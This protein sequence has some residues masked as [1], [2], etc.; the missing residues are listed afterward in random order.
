MN[1]DLFSCSLIVSAQ[2][3]PEAAVDHPETIWQLAK[4]S[5]DQGV[6]VLRLQGISNIRYIK[7]RWNGPVI[8]LIKRDFA[9]SEIY[10]TPTKQEVSELIEAGVEVIALDATPRK[11]PGDESLQELVQLIHSKG[12]RAMGD[13]DSPESIDYAI[14][15]GCDFIGT[16]LAGYTPARKMTPGPDF[17]LLRYAVSKGFPVIA[18][19]RYSERWEVE[20]ALRIGASAVV[21][22]GAINDPVKQTNRFLIPNRSQEKIGAVDIGGTWIRFAVFQNDSI[23]EIRKEPLPQDREIRMQWIRDQ[24]AHSGVKRLGVGTG[25][26]VDPRTGEVW[27]AKPIIPGHQGSFFNQQMLGIPT[28]ALNDGLATAFGHACHPKFAGKNVATLALGTGVGA[29]FIRRGEILHG[30]RGEYPRLNDV[31]VGGGE[32]VEQHLGGAALSPNPTQEQK[33]KA[34]EAVQVVVRLVQEMMYPDEIVIAGSVGLS[35]WLLPI[36]QELNCT[37]SP[38]GSDAGLYGSYW[39][40]RSSF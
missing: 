5:L 29:G 11:R 30:K 3:S 18:E 36:L 28:K 34:I 19:G 24:I 10:I 20:A 26:T 4:C 27:E 13:C 21:I 35:D 32:T 14:K 9:D 1:L 25:G 23:V 7:E 6:R 12:I 22:G 31:L 40:A 39:L 17:D 37:P 33:A 38:Y 8:G 15:C 16:T 2:A